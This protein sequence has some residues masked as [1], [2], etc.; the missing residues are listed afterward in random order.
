[1]LS[2]GPHR[3]RAATAVACAAVAGGVVT[4]A[5]TGSYVTSAISVGGALLVTAITAVASSHRQTR[6]LS[7]DREK[8]AASIRAE[9]RRQASALERAAAETDL[10]DVRGLLDGMMQAIR[11][12]DEVRD[13]IGSGRSPGLE[14]IR[15]ARRSIDEHVDLCRLRCD[16]SDGLTLSY[17]EYRDAFVRLVEGK[18]GALAYDIARERF[19]E[20][21]TER[22]ARR[23]PEPV[24][25]A[26]VVS[27]SRR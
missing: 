16:A 20:I 19:S 3:H 12:G 10:A 27:S 9:D 1:M 14:A 7:A 11:L 26:L 5:A 23:R 15:A 22:F 6:D 21:A 2:D 8:Q 13:Q 17:H 4:V 18:T 24:E 25:P